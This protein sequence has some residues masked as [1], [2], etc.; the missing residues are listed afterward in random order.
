METFTVRDMLV[1][2]TDLNKILCTYE[3]ILKNISDCESEENSS[4]EP[5]DINQTVRIVLYSLIF[6]LSVVGN[7]LIIAVLVRNRRMRTVTNL[8]LLSLSVSDLMVSLV[9]IP[10]TLIPNLMKDFIFGI[11]ICK[12][13]MY[14]MGVSV[15]VSTFNLVAIS[16]ERYSAICNPLTSRAWQTKSHAAKVITATWAVSFILMLPYPISSTLKPFT[17]FNNSTGHMCRLMWPNDI[18]QQSWYVSLLLIL[19]LIPGIVMMTAYGLISVELYRGIKFELSSR[20]A[21]RD[22]QSSTGSIKPGDSDGCY[23]QPSNKKKSTSSSSNSMVGRVCSASPTANLVAKKR[24]IR[25]L[26][27]IVF[28]FFICWTPIFVVNAWQAFDRRSAHQLTGAPISFIHLLSYTSACVNP[29]IYCFMNK[30][31][32]QGMLS[33]FSCWKKRQGGSFLGRSAGT[34]TVRAKAEQNGHTPPS[35][36][37]TKFTYTGIKASTWNEMA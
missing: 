15:S 24:V 2:S 28:L 3:R 31:F 14:F 10:F 25:M 37:S 16:L 23:L 6:L 7:S 26:L 20:K 19:F 1:N 17:R 29:I 35:G 18:I 30:R 11:G 33:T 27:V 8:F 4:P 32:R 36:A 5:K 34:G 13:V 22:R 12:L 9:C 21:S